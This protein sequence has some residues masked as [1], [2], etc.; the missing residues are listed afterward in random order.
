MNIKDLQ[1]FFGNSLKYVKSG[2]DIY[3]VD[4]NKLDNENANYGIWNCFSKKDAIDGDLVFSDVV[5]EYLLDDA[6]ERI[7]KEMCDDFY[8]TQI[9]ETAWEKLCTA[10]LADFASILNGF[11]EIYVGSTLKELCAIVGEEQ[12]IDAMSEVDIDLCAYPLSVDIKL[13]IE[14]YK[15]LTEEAFT[16]DT[17]KMEKLV[18]KAGK[19]KGTDR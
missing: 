10:H 3:I 9:T 1:S 13:S 5:P 8:G 16:V 14:A 7:L 2:D 15:K 6:T 11:D 4:T 19:Y 17:V 18:E 12:N